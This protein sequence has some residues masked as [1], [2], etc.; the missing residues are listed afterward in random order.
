MDSE[1]LDQ[2]VDR[3]RRGEDR[4]ESFRHLFD[5]FHVPIYRFFSRRGFS[6]NECL[7]L[8]QEAFLGVYENITSFR[9]GSSFRTWLFGILANLA[10]NQRRYRRASK[11]SGREV[12]LEAE[13]SGRAKGPRPTLS[14]RQG[15][16]EGAEERALRMERTALLNQA[17]A[18][19][20]QAM[21]QILTLR[22]INELTYREIAQNRG[23]AVDTVR[24]HLYQARERLRQVLE[25]SDRL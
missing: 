11:R 18:E 14:D 5:H 4:E 24:S 9:G 20:P 19:L 3:L 12:P 7:D 25:E 23:L 15:E 1:E 17:I 22:V 13:E 2:A 21:R 8:T 16:L 10:S 6:P